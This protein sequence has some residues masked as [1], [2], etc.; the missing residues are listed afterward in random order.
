[1]YVNEVG[2]ADHLKQNVFVKIGATQS[3]HY[4]FQPEEDLKVGQWVELL[5]GY[6]A[7]YESSRE[8]HGYGWKNMVLGLPSDS[9]CL[10]ARLARGLDDRNDVTCVLNEMTIVKLCESFEFVDD[11]IFAPL[12]QLM[13][14][15]K[16]VEKR[17]DSTLR[18]I[19]WLNQR[20]RERFEFFAS[21]PVAD[22]SE[23]TLAN[24][25]ERFP[26]KKIASTYATKCLKRRWTP[27]QISPLSNLA[28]EFSVTE[29]EYEALEEYCFPLVDVEGES[30][31]GQVLRG[32]L[33]KPMDET[34]WCPI[35][36]YLIRELCAILD[37]DRACAD[38]TEELCPEA[39]CKNFLQ[40]AREAAEAVRCP[41][42][43]EHLLFESGLSPHYSLPSK[44]ADVLN[45]LSNDLTASAVSTVPKGYLAAIGEK[46]EILEDC[47]LRNGEVDTAAIEES[48]KKRMDLTRKCLVTPCDDKSTSELACATRFYATDRD[49]K[50][51]TL[52]YLVWQVAYVVDVFANVY[53]AESSYSIDRLCSVMKVDVRV[54]TDAIKQG[55][56]VHSPRPFLQAKPRLPVKNVK[57]ETSRKKTTN[58]GKIRR[59]STQNSRP[60]AICIQ[61]R[62]PEE[63]FLEFPDWAK[64]WTKKT[65]QRQSGDSKGGLD[66]YWYTPE[67]N[68]KLRSILQIK[69]F[70]T[71][72]AA[73]R[74]DE[75][76]AYALFQK[77][78]K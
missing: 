66:H 69:R 77:R 46:L 1:M 19:Y 48:A 12:T 58:S 50:P 11:Q 47:Y 10:S 76:A 32:R 29:E 37:M 53:L 75:T 4:Y 6:G 18:R 36:V 21:Q 39:V 3:I 16:K 57:K 67:N 74:G 64:G 54:V 28:V 44:M 13:H 65:F 72:L 70:L 26:T 14:S 25:D 59:T 27:S 31:H 68:F 45:K 60:S 73:T 62:P 61:E 38:Q 30:R 78:G 24:G 5:T 2:H 23:Q 35:A 22:D 42:R 49:L 51:H 55:I 63:K 71:C 20:F 17:F 40:C 41:V 34:M 43:V 7:A 56:F 15:D 8:R 33:V 9:S 52:W